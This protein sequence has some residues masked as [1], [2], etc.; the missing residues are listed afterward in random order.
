MLSVAIE[1]VQYLH[2]IKISAM[3]TLKNQR[4]TALG[5]LSI[6]IPN[7]VINP[8]TEAQLG[9]KNISR[10]LE[11]DP[12][13]ILASLPDRLNEIQ[14]NLKEVADG[15]RVLQEFSTRAGF[16]HVKKTWPEMLT[17]SLLFLTNELLTKKTET[18][19]NKEQEAQLPAIKV[20]PNE[21]IEILVT[22]IS[23][24]IY[25]FRYYGS[26][27]RIETFIRDN[28]LSTVITG[29]DNLE[30][31]EIPRQSL[32]DRFVEAK[33]YSPYQFSLDVVR[34]IVMSNYRGNILFN[35]SDSYSR[36]ILEIPIES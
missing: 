36:V 13:A 30:G 9:L 19:R 21:I 11:K 12:D 25:R 20:D 4:L 26:T 35:E 7:E 34:E 22:L 33:S 27:L 10:R 6:R 15:V 2:T 8:L 24:T 32:S 16:M 1:N 3:K 14:R 29:I 31:I 23:L 28:F 18:Q 17:E 5:T